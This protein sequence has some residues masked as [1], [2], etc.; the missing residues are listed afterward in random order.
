MQIDRIIREVQQELGVEVDGKAG[1]QTWAAIHR[2]VVPSAIQS[3]LD[4]ATDERTNARSERVIATLDAM[5]QP[6][7]RALYFKAR[8]NGITVNIISGLRSFQEQGALYAQGR[9]SPGN[10]VTNARA[11]HSVH[12]FGLAFDV[13]IFEGSRF[14]GES[15]QYKAVG[16]LGLELGLE[17][18]GN[19]RTIVDE[20][21]FQLRPLWAK[22]LTQRQMLAQLR[23]RRGEGRALV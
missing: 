1:P 12:N 9:T 23:Q 16:A 18:G 13:G 3:L 6:Y 17:W 7:A 10:I 19:W 8:D 11:G 2:R 4:L 21:H 14:L 20:P 22:E 5:V 15:P